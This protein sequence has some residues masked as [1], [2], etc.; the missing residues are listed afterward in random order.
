MNPGSTEVITRTIVMR[1]GSPDDAMEIV[2]PY[3]R[4]HGSAV[5]KA[6]NAK[7]ITIRGIKSEVA[8]AISQI[9]A[10]DARFCALPAPAPSVS[11]PGGTPGKD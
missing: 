3:L 5:Y 7:V 4:S 9:D 6:T 8:E 10:L 2:T 11:Q 1:C